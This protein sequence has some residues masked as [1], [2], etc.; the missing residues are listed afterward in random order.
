MTIE[1]KSKFIY[2]DPNF[3]PTELQKQYIESFAKEQELKNNSLSMAYKPDCKCECKMDYI[4]DRYPMSEKIHTNCPICKKHILAELIRPYIF[5]YKLWD[6]E[7]SL[8]EITIDFL[9]DKNHRQI[10]LIFQYQLEYLENLWDE[11][12]DIE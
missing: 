11:N 2:L 10:G 4:L 5:Y 8:K 1:K 12:L 6:K 3:K 9:L 7:Y